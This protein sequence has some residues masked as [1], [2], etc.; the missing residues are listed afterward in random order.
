MIYANNGKF[1]ARTFEEGGPPL[2]LSRI[3][4]RFQGLRLYTFKGQ[5]GREPKITIPLTYPALIWNY[6]LPPGPDVQHMMTQYCDSINLHYQDIVP[7]FLIILCQNQE[8]GPHFI[9]G[10]PNLRKLPRCGCKAQ[11]NLQQPFA[12]DFWGLKALELTAKPGV[13]E[14]KSQLLDKTWIWQCTRNSS[15]C[16][17]IIPVPPK[18][19]G[20]ARTFVVQQMNINATAP[21][22][23][24]FG[25]DLLDFVALNRIIES[26]RVYD[27]LKDCAGLTD[28]EIRELQSRLARIQAQALPNEQTEAMRVDQYYCAVLARRNARK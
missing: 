5:L 23:R 27:C 6:I 25:Y 26:E 2:T 7:S 22:K 24:G 18:E 1:V 14:K 11:W 17:W 19:R 8:L 15:G 21:T 12:T 3:A 20:D 9:Q 13:S 4:K 28:L 16:G 10:F